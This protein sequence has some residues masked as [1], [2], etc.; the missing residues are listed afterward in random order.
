MPSEAKTFLLKQLREAF[1]VRQ[2]LDEER[3]EY[4]VSLFRAK[5][6]LPPIEITHD[7]A[8]IDGRHRYA[9]AKHLGLKSIKATVVREKDPIKLISRAFN[10]NVGGPL[11][12]TREDLMLAIGQMIKEKATR[13]RILT[14]FNMPK[15]MVAAV[16]HSVRLRLDQ[17]KLQRAVDEVSRGKVNATQAAKK[18]GVKL[19]N[20]QAAIR[21]RKKKTEKNEPGNQRRL[22]NDRCTRFRIGMVHQLRHLTDQCRDGVVPWATGDSVVQ[23]TGAKLKQMVTLW[24][25]QEARFNAAKKTHGKK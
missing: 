13:E 15:E 11:Q 6:E 16:Y 24:E 14:G 4:F 25:N 17:E 19:P 20:L 23:Y 21:G 1:Y 2:S 9:A 18:H 5:A 22:V 12:P 3:I 7:F 8:I 10:A